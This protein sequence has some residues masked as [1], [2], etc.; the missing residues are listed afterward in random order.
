MIHRSLFIKFYLR[1]S[2]KKGSFG[3]LPDD[4]DK[5][6]NIFTSRIPNIKT[7][8][9]DDNFITNSMEKVLGS[10]SFPN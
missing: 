6:R 3:T 2:T 10:D 5:I 8:T 1:R 9:L 7:E 4:G